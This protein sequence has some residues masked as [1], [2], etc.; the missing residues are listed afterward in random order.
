MLLF[1]FAAWK[2][3]LVRQTHLFAPLNS[4]NEIVPMDNGTGYV[5]LFY[6]FGIANTFRYQESSPSKFPH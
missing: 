1:N 5:D 4:Q 2:L 6:L 3:P